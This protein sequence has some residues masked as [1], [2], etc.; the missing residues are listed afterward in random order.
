LACVRMSDRPYRGKL[1]RV[2]LHRVPLVLDLLL[3]E[4]PKVVL[5]HEYTQPHRYDAQSGTTRQFIAALLDWAMQSQP[6]PTTVLCRAALVPRDPDGGC[7]TCVYAN[8]HPAQ[9]AGLGSIHA[10][11]GILQAGKAGALTV[12]LSI[13]VTEPFL[14][15]PTRSASF[16]PVAIALLPHCPWHKWLATGTP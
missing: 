14:A 8:L 4:F 16:L 12:L 3:Q 11:V 13:V 15:F 9:A 10:C 2:C 5:L 6:A 7:C 1:S